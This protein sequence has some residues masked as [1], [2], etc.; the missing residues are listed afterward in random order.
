MEVHGSTAG[1]AGTAE[2]GKALPPNQPPDDSAPVTRGEFRET[3]L[4]MRGE[5]K[6]EINATKAELKE[7]ISNVKA[8]LKEDIHKSERRVLLA[9]VSILVTVVIAIFS[10]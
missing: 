5:F 7:D 3:T 2:A 6:E 8:E 1:T 4:L 10:G 9:L